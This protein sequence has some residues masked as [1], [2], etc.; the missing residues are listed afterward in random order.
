MIAKNYKTIF[1]SNI[2]IIPPEAKDTIC[3][4]VN[5]ID[6][7]YDARMRLVFSAAEPIEQLYNRGY[8]ILEYARTHSR[9]LEMQSEDYF[10]KENNGD[11]L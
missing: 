3:L 10:T 6:V 5:L 9:L 4:F 2:P 1:I 8:M 11:A 7:L